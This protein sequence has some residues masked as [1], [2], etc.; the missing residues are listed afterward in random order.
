MTAI[1]QTIDTA[2]GAFTMLVDD[3]QR[4]LASG[5]TADHDAILGRLAG[6]RD[7]AVGPDQHGGRQ[8][9]IVRDGAVDVRAVECQAALGQQ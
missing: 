5:W 8:L 4:V 7:V 9:V 6:P 2:D 1:I 3:R